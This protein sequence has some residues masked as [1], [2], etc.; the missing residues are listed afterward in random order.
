MQFGL[1]ESQ[2][3]LKHTAKRFFGG[4]L[5]M[6]AVRRIMETSTAHDEELWTKMAGQGFTGIIFPEEFGG[7]GLGQVELILLMEE[8][9]YALLPGPRRAAYLAGCVGCLAGDGRVSELS[10][11]LD[12]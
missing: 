4:E 6:A 9:G 10:D 2:E 8:A 5:A 3:M 1:N 7:M 12:C 11:S